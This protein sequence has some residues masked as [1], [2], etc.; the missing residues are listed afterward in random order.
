M[1]RRNPVLAPARGRYC[2]LTLAEW[3][4]TIRVLRGSGWWVWWGT[5]QHREATSDLHAAVIGAAVL[6]LPVAWHGANTGRFKPEW[7][8][9]RAGIVNARAYL[10]A[11]RAAQ[12]VADGTPT[13]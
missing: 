13:V 11:A 6:L 9:Q 7:Y 3:R 5:A 8:R 4:G 2:G 10:R 1:G 12:E